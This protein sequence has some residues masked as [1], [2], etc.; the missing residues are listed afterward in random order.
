M[1]DY[2]LSEVESIFKVPQH[3]L[4]HLCEKNVIV[5]D[6]QQTG[7]RGSFR[8]FSDKNLFEFA[9]ALELKKFQIPLSVIKALLIVLSA[10]SKKILAHE[11]QESFVEAFKYLQ[12]DLY[13]FDGKY[14]VLDFARMQRNPDFAATKNRQ[15]LGI[16][17]GKFLENKS[18]SVSLQ[19]LQDLPNKFVGHLKISL[20]SI[21]N[22]VSSQI[23]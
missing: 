16:D 18:K 6:I 5:P 17:I 13:I 21:C 14:V 19:R 22:Q 10:T 3:V 4:I 9:V 23:Q 15:M 8:K 2:K 12:A 11:N 20:S 1:A 7:G